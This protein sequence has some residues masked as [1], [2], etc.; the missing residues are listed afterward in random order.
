MQAKYSDGYRQGIDRGA[1]CWA[2]S[3]VEDKEAQEIHIQRS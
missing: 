1:F 3:R 2:G